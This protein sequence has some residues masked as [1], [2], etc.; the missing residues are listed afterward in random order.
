M[1]VTT[2][3]MKVLRALITNFYSSSEGE[4]TWSD[5]I[6]DASEPSG[7]KGKALAGVCGSLA[8]K[9]LVTTGGE[10]RDSYIALTAAGCEAAKA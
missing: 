2:N 9:G 10:G 7:L 3:E 1:N 6:N 8:A 5:V 4:P